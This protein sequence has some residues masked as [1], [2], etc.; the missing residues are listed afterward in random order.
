MVLRDAENTCSP[1]SD[2][3]IELKIKNV[4]IIEVSYMLVLAGK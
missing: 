4:A 2:S 3:I 1:S